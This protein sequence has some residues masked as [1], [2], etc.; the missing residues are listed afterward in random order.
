MSTAR[1][2]LE[3]IYIERVNQAVE[4]DDLDLVARLAREY[5]AELDRLQA[6]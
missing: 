2:A 6:A 4:V 1:T 3:I 5:D